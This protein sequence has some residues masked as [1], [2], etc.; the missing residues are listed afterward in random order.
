MPIDA[1]RENSERPTPSETDLRPPKWLAR[2]VEALVPPELGSPNELIGVLLETHGS[3]AQTVLH[4]PVAVA[5][6]ALGRARDAFYWKMALAQTAILFLPFVDIL[7]LPIVLNLGLVLA[8]LIIR[9]G[10]IHKTD[11]TE[12]EAITSLMTPALIIFFNAALGWASPSL[13]VAGD[14]IIQRAAKLAV[15]IALCRYL[16]GKDPGPGHPHKD[17]LRLANRTWFFNGVWMAGALVVLTTNADAVPPILPLQ[18][19]FTSF[20]TAHTF[21]LSWR[22]Q[23]NPLDG[24][25]RHQRIQVLLNRNP[26]IDDLKRKRGLLL[27]G[28]NWFNGFSAQALFEMIFFM[29]L[30]LPLLIGLGE[31]YLGYP[32]AAEISIPQMA[33]NGGG[34]VVLLLTWV[35]IKKLNRQTAAVFDQKLRELRA[36]EGR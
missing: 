12:C 19:A 6:P 17:L 26:Y 3:I 7:S 35:Q 18:E 2:I 14:G 27:T 31:L 8:V 28:A 36:S 1:G 34:W 9:E 23:L 30:P 25:T 33:V 22:L 24:I 10:Y 20:L 11:R 29:L 32:G 5:P 16:L 21:T 13:M 15:P 4:I